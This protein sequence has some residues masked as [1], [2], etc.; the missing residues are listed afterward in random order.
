MLLLES[1]KFTCSITSISQQSSCWNDRAKLEV[2][3]TH[4]FGHV[5]EAVFTMCEYPNKVFFNRWLTTVNFPFYLASMNLTILVILTGNFQKKVTSHQCWQTTRRN[6]S[7]KRAFFGESQQW[8][9]RLSNQI[10]SFRLE[11]HQIFRLTC[12]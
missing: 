5:S 6:F 9:T 11:I 1:A 8:V 7:I 12:N 10:S 4:E 2:T 3:F